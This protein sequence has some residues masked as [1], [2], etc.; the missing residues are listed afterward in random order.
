MIHV[1]GRQRAGGIATG[2]DCV[3]DVRLRLD[4][5]VARNRNTLPELVSALES[6]LAELLQ[7]VAR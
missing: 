1:S 5:A 4:I 3:D 7:G 6:E 2:G